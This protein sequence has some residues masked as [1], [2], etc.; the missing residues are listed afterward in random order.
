MRR[1]GRTGHKDGNHDEVVEALEKHGAEIQS[2]AGVGYGCPDIVLSYEGVT[3]L[4]EI[5]DGSKPP[6]GRKLTDK[7]KE[8]VSRW[9]APVY[10]VNSPGEAIELLRKLADKS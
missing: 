10:I 3:A 5:K 7:E 9:K 4:V 1:L 6:S 8:F 2:L